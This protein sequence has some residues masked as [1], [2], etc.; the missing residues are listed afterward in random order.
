MILPVTATYA[1]YSEMKSSIM[2]NMQRRAEASAMQAI[3]S[4]NML[5]V[6]GMVSA[7]ESL[8]LMIKKIIEGQHLK[9]L[10]LV[11]TDVEKI[12]QMSEENSLS[13]R[14]VDDTTKTLKVLSVELD[15]TV[16]NF[17]V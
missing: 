9:S 17:R 14:Q 2:D 8:R 13:I 3:D 16:K 12:A 4:A 10:H 15:A 7:P 1:V 11:R 5:M 6:T